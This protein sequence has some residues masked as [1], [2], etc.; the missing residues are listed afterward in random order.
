M[1]NAPPAAGVP[2]ALS[3]YQVTVPVESEAAVNACPPGG[4]L[5]GLL[6]LSLSWTVITPGAAGVIGTPAEALD[7]GTVN[8]TLEAAA[9]RMS[10]ALEIAPVS[11]ADAAVSV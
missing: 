3:V 2:H 7:G 8:A 5:T 6:K 4:A 10:K 1:V 9:G 11:G